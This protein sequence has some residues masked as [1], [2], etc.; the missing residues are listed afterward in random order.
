MWLR[1]FLMMA[2]CCRK[3]LRGLLARLR[4]GVTMLGIRIGILARIM[5]FGLMF[6]LCMSFRCGGLWIP[7][8]MLPRFAVRVVCRLMLATVDGCTIPF[9]LRLRV[10]GFRSVVMIWPL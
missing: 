2:V 3:V 6:R 1:R 8:L 7:T 9:G 5:L 10:I 4:V